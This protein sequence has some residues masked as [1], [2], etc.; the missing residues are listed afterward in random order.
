MQA[1]AQ[2]TRAEPAT[3]AVTKADSVTS[4]DRKT[5]CTMSS[6]ID[7]RTRESLYIELA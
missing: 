1:E 3:T 7:D 2:F 6:Q 5:P 4:R